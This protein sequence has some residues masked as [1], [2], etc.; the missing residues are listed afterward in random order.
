[1]TRS[2]SKTAAIV[3]LVTS[4]LA[5]GCDGPSK[6]QRDAKRE[7]DRMAMQLAD[8]ERDR[9]TYKSQIDTL[10]AGLNQAT[11]KQRVAEA[12]LTRAQDELAAG[13]NAQANGDAL[14]AQ[15]RAAQQ[16][17]TDSQNHIKEMQIQ[18]EALKAQISSAPAVN[19]APSA[20]SMSK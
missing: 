15:L 12:Q 2:I 20:P 19:P 16:Q 11:E 13:R 10:Q 17:L 3:C 5:I 9:D 4:L 8:A 6:A 18:I 14:A 7:Q 1:M